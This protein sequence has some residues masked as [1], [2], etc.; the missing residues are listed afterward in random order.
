MW[1][2]LE[3]STLADLQAGSDERLV[4]RHN[5]HCSQFTFQSGVARLQS[6]TTAAKVRK[7]RSYMLPEPGGK[8][9]SYNQTQKLHE[10]EICILIY[11]VDSS[12]FLTKAAERL[13]PDGTR[14]TE[15]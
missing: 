6:G 7:K 15:P 4:T 12:P 3:L 5:S 13:D 9:M 8:L 2:G 1:P 11:S 14:R 10:Y